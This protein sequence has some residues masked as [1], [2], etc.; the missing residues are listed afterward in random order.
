MER[1]KAKE[2]KR[3]GGKVKDPENLPEASKGDRRD[4]VGEKIGVSGRT[5]EKGKKVKE[6]AT[7]TALSKRECLLKVIV[8]PERMNPS[9]RLSGGLC[10]H[11]NAT[12]NG[13]DKTRGHQV[14]LCRD[15]HPWGVALS[16][17]VS[18]HL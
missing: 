9:E 8:R 13:T 12:F 15:N 16:R 2:R 5:F 1:E 18:I 7:C 6:T 11:G 10:G 3:D 17:S 14:G 4:K